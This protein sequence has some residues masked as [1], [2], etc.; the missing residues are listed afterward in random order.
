MCDN[1]IKNEYK[2]GIVT[3]Y[4]DSLNYGGNL[5]A[6]ALC[7]FLEKQ[8]YKPEQIRL[9]TSVDSENSFVKNTL[10][11]LKQSPLVFFRKAKK[12]I[13]Y[14]IK[15]IRYKK[16][17]ANLISDN[18]E[19][20]ENFHFNLIPHTEK[21]YNNE[22]L[23]ELVDE[24]SAFITGSDQ[25][26]HPQAYNPA[27]FLSFVP[28]DKL[29]LSYAASISTSV[30]SKEQKERFR[31]HLADFKAISVREQSAVELLKDISPVQPVCSVDPTLLLDKEDWDEIATNPIIKEPYV[32][33]YFLGSG[34]GIRKIAKQYAAK[35]GLKVVSIPFL[36]NMYNKYDVKYSDQT[37]RSASPEQFISLV[38]NAECIV[39]DSFHAT[40]FSSIYSKEF[41]VF[42]RENNATMSVRI[43]TLTKLFGTQSRICNTKDKGVVEYMLNASDIDYS[44]NQEYLEVKEQSKNYLLGVLGR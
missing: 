1:K 33:C 16:F 41:F 15:R 29:K 13:K 37:V 8:D 3:H 19:A 18:W 4:N 10:S 2:I 27:Y 40:V 21:E 31:K 7:K 30:L 34:K 23:T 6:Y 42:E 39:T 14:K 5:Q 36:Q 25:V 11:V 20:F 9:D 17:V 28:S 26:W 35:K 24:Y 44:N 12:F 22:T 43:E 32:F 38:K